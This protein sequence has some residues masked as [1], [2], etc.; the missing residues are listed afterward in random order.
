MNATCESIYLALTKNVKPDLR[1][2][3]AFIRPHSI[4]APWQANFHTISKSSTMFCDYFVQLDCITHYQKI[5]NRN[6]ILEG[7]NL[8]CSG[9]VSRLQLV[10]TYS[11]ECRKASTKQTRKLIPP[12]LLNRR[13]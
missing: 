2:V 12:S 3:S 7:N 1:E 10:Y 5:S 8:T 9:L 13:T 6:F 4:E 11:K